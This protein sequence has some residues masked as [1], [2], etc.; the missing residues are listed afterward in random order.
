MINFLLVLLAFTPLV[1]ANSFLYPY[2][3]GKVLFIRTVITIVLVLFSFKLFNRNFRREVSEK[4]RI[5]FKSKLFLAVMAYFSIFTLSAVFAFDKIRAFAGMPERGEGFIGIFFFVAAFIIFLLL[6]DKKHWQWFFRI[7]LAAGLILFI[8]QLSYVLKDVYNPISLIGNRSFFAIYFL[9]VLFCAVIVWQNSQMLRDRFWLY[10]SGLMV[11]LSIIA[12]F[13]TDKKGPLASLSAGLFVFLIYLIIRQKG[14]RKLILTGLIF[15]LI[16]GGLFFATRSVEV[17]QKIPGLRR[18]AKASFLDQTISARMASAGISLDAVNPATNGFNR[19]LLGWGWDNYHI[20][21]YKNY[22]PE[23]Y[24]YESEPFD[25]S[26][27]KLLDVLVMNGILGLLAYLSI[28]FL[29]FR[30]LFRKPAENSDGLIEAALLFFGVAYFVQN[31][32]TFDQIS[33]Y[34]SFF[35]LLAFS[36]FYFNPVRG[37]TPPEGVSAG[38]ALRAG[39]TSNGT[40]FYAWLVSAFAVIFLIF[41]TIVPLIQMKQFVTLGD[42]D[43]REGVL[44]NEF[45][46]SR[47]FYADFDIRRLFVVG[48]VNSNIT[49]AGSMRY[50]ERALSKAEEGL[51][52]A[53]GNINPLY[54]TSLA[55]GYQK[56]GIVTGDA[57]N[58]LIAEK[59]YKQALQLSPRYQPTYFDYAGSLILQGR[60]DEAENV[61]REALALN[62]DSPSAQF[63]MAVFL[64]FQLRKQDIS[65][66]TEHIRDSFS[67]GYFIMNDSNYELIGRIA[68][69]FYDNNDP[70]HFM[71]LFDLLSKFKP[72]EA[73]P[74]YL[75]LYNRNADYVRTNGRLPDKF[76]FY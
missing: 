74:Y 51:E 2:V 22:N 60:N 16:F 13:M 66:A 52:S 10:F 27:N 45:I 72:E 15:M 18:V 73:G 69:Y 7:I 41:F 1:V 46:F 43:K 26:H 11:P 9:F 59:Y 42:P 68:K 4:S 57:E 49:D 38:H 71:E 62:P 54:L 23:F 44:T 25:R 53:K 40:V 34:I 39:R 61:M 63:H 19:L 31:L 5:L 76:E 28:W 35:V 55:A 33:T 17:W 64:I 12:I 37:K 30:Q 6:F 47:Y 8:H 32:Y 36:I 24:T 65:E 48:M 29:F 14:S 3:N 20:A 50:L 70:E 67:S 75:G 56:K 58:F 21:W